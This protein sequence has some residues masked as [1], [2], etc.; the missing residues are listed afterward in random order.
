MKVAVVGAGM[1][2]LSAAYELA[3]AGVEVA[4]FEG[5]S[6]IGGK[7]KRATV[8]GIT[9][10]VGAESILARRPEGLELA[11]QVGLGDK[12]VHPATTSAS[13]WTAGQQRPMPPTV[14]GIPADLDALNASGILP[15]HVANNP[16]PAPEHD[17]SVAEFVEQRVG[18]DVVDRLVEPLLGG[19]YAGH[20]DRLS[21]QAAAPQI[22]ALGDDLLASAAAYRA[23]ASA[24]GPVFFGLRGGVG[25]LPDAIVEAGQFAVHTE[26]PVRA[27]SAAGGRWNLTLGPVSGARVESFDAVIVATPA[28]AAGRLLA[29]VAPD[30]AFALAGVDYASMAIVT[31]VLDGATPPAG[32][33]FLVPPVD[34]TAIK[35]ATYATNKWPW[36]AHESN[37]LT[38]IRTSI[39]RAGDT[40]LLHLD[41]ARVVEVAAADLASAMGSLGRVVDTHVQRWGGGLPQYDVGHLD[42]VAT[43]E[44]AVAKVDG[45]QVC[46]A[47]YRG[48]GIPAV[49][50]SGRAAARRIFNEG[51]IKS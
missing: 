8:G 41:D 37:G 45:L 9:L 48:V 6:R 27:I 7:L 1:A 33:G 11:T 20:A 35:A 51:T 5:T 12:I 28:P 16:A 36:L 40:A 49:I 46:G 30:A 38:V 15:G 31:F 19:V 24:T 29:E 42:L 26:T 44:A 2:G 25:Q 43:V 17:V 21:L 47:A 4:V 13:I 22:H 39:G 23:N 50:A 3:Q 18:R 14:M 34:G 10:D 32:S